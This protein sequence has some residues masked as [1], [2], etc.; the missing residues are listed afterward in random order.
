MKISLPLLLFGAVMVLP[1][2]AQQTL[3]GQAPDW[4]LSDAQGDYVSFYEDSANQ[5]SLLVFWTPTCRAKC[6]DA[7]ERLNDQAHAQGIKTYLLLNS[8]HTRHSELP[9]LPARMTPLFKAHAVG[10]HYGVRGQPTWVLVDGK[11]NILNNARVGG[12]QPELSRL[13]GPKP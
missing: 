10:R 4:L 7:M 6:V 5:P 13:L 3:H 11:K 9:T 2:T 1:V 8:G 12:A